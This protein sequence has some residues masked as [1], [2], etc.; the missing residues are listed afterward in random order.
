VKLGTFRRV[1]GDLDR[2]RTRRTIG[3]DRCRHSQHD[4][5]EFLQLGEL[6]R[7]AA[8]SADFSTFVC[9]SLSGRLRLV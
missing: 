2:L 1:M 8:R 4:R 9:A 6:E 7:I 5:F 3:E